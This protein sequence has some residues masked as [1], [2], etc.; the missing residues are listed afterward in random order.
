M[1]NDVI[2]SVVGA[3]ALEKRRHESL[4]DALPAKLRRHVDAPHSAFMMRLDT[5]LAIE[6]GD[7]YQHLAFECAHHEVAVS[8][9]FQTSGRGLDG[10][11]LMLFR[12]GAKSARLFFK[13]LHA[14]APEI[15]RV[16]GV[17]D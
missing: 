16:G 17:E 7:S 1:Q 15:F 9:R 5:V 3:N 14:Q 13:T 10:E 11:P 4:C 12:R 6:T 2:E 8:L